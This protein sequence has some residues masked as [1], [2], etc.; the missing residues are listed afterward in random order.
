M[1]KTATKEAAS[2]EIVVSLKLLDAPA[3]LRSLSAAAA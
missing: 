1:Q 2:N 3:F